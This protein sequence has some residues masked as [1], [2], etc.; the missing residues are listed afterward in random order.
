VAA[1]CSVAFSPDWRIKMLVK[2]LE[3]IAGP[4]WSYAPG[5][6]VEID[7]EWGAKL[8]DGYRAIEINPDG[9][10]KTATKPAKAAKTTPQIEDQPADGI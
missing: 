3:G 10:P 6:I 2:F 1:V 4:D 5:Q 8:A 7:E 9:T